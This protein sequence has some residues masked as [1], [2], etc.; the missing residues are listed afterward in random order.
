M[1]LEIRIEPADY[2]SRVD[3][4]LLDQKRDLF[5]C[6][7]TGETITMNDDGLTCSVVKH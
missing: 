4:V 3:S 6:S 2:V 1:H 7:E 5:Y